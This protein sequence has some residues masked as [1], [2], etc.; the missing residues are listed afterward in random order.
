MERER[1]EAER[2]AAAERTTAEAERQRQEEAKKAKE[3]SRL[4]FVRMMEAKLAADLAS[5]KAVENAK[6]F[7]EAER[8]AEA[9]RASGANSEH[10][11]RL[12]Q[13]QE[14]KDRDA[15]LARE[16]QEKLLARLKAQQEK[17]GMPELDLERSIAHLKGEAERF[18][19]EQKRYE[20]EA[21]AGAARLAEFEARARQQAEQLENLRRE[22]EMQRSCSLSAE[23]SQKDKRLLVSWVLGENRQPTSYDW[24]G[25]FSVNSLNPKQYHTYISTEST[26][27]SSHECPLP[28]EPGLYVCLFFHGKSHELIATS[29]QIYLGP[30]LEMV[31]TADPIRRVITMRYEVKTGNPTTKDWIGFYR[32]DKP[33]RQY[34]EYKWLQPDRLSG[35]WEV[36]MPRRGG[37]DYEFRFFSHTLRQPMQTSNKVKL[38]KEDY[39]SIKSTDVLDLHSMVRDEVSW[40]IVSVDPTNWDWIELVSHPD[41][42]RVTWNYIDSNAM[43]AT[44]NRPRAPGSYRYRYW[45]RSIGSGPVALSPVFEVVNRDKLTVADIDGVLQVTHDV[46]SVE[47]NT[48]CWVGLYPEGSDKHITYQYIASPSDNNKT[49]KFTKPSAGRYEVRF[50]SSADKK[51]SVIKSAPFTVQ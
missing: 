7:S 5:H 36:K 20:E 28:T 49:L 25:V 51:N 10:N 17:L 33:H 30:S 21:A 31:A 18:I 6:A 47:N 35:V 3:A 50:F 38:A 1:E 29:D 4:E 37:Y 23:Y 44:F 14:L 22:R 32:S 9:E 27:A 16:A 11:N 34:I 8:L 13:L 2:A 24:I 43:H 39:L 15:A 19:I 48:S 40:T 12:A 42:K 46:L 26:A 41:N 45:A